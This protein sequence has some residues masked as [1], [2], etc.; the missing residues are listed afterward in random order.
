MRAVALIDGE[1]Y[2]G[3]RAR[4]AARAA[5]RVGRRD[6]RRRLREASRRR[7]ATACRSSTDSAAPRSVV[8]LSDEP[9]LG[10]R[11]AA[12]LGLARARARDCPTSAP[13]SA[14]T[15]RRYEAFPLP[16]LAVIGTGKRVGKTAVTAHLARLLAR[17]RDVV[18]V[19]MGRGGPREPELI[20]YAARRSTSSSRSRA[21]GGTRRPT[22][23]RSAA[24]AGVPTIGCRRAGGGLRGRPF[25]SNVVEG[26]RLA[27]GRGARRSSSST[28][29]APRSRRS[30]STARVLV[31]GPGHDVDADL[32]AYRRLVSDLVVVGRLRASMARVPV[33]AAAPARSAAARRAASRSSPPGPATRRTSTPTSS[34]SRG[35]SR[36]RDALRAELARLDADTYL[37]ELKAAAI[38]VVAEHALAHG[39]RVVLAANDVVAAGLDEPLLALVAGGGRA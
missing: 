7:D 20:E 10:P 28:G 3:R 21:P 26:A 35:T 36:D 13:T 1:H 37:V 22:T 5:V 29:A 6:P 16:S 30:R 27:A 33:D 17:D 18:V 34:T 32:N 25:V 9:V 31:V 39:R 12:S 4:R 19:A 15:R 24:L 38:D 11:R 8:D 2:A 23:S 14:S